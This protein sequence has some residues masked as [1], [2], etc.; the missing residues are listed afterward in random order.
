MIVPSTATTDSDLQAIVGLW[1]LR[2]SGTDATCIIALN[3]T[4]EAGGYG[5]YIERCALQI[6]GAGARWRPG[7]D[8]FDLIDSHGDL[9][10]TFR[11]VAVDVYEAAKGEYL[12]TR[13]PVI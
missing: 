13:A 5:V 2:T 7:P 4:A 6:I 8:G 11:R 1:S 9:T 10:L 3:R 12:L